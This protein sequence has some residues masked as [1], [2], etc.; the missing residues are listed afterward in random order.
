MLQLDLEQQLEGSRHGAE[1]RAHSRADL[2]GGDAAGTTT[3]APAATGPGGLPPKPDE[4]TTAKYLAALIAIDP[5]IV[6]DKPD[7]AV[8]RGRDQCSSVAQHPHDTAGL[9]KLTNQ[10]FTSPKHPEG[11]GDAKSTRILAAVRAHVCPT[12]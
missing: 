12:F 9:V 3:A 11:L 8:S 6:G 1:Q 4:A 2:G 10:R 7:R 5:E